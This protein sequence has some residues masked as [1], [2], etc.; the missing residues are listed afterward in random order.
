MKPFV[1]VALLL[2]L[3]AA[4]FISESQEHGGYGGYGMKKRMGGAGFCTKFCKKVHPWNLL[5]RPKCRR[6]CS[7]MVALTGNPRGKCIKYC[8]VGYNKSID[9]C[10]KI[11]DS[12]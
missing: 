10:H 3:V 2:F 6:G 11:C 9:K 7:K 1:F 5:A 4:L 12:I 8:R